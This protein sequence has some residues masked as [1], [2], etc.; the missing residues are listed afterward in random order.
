MAAASTIT[1]ITATGDTTTPCTP[2]I[3]TGECVSAL[4]LLKHLAC[5]W[6]CI[7][8]VLVLGPIATLAGNLGVL[9]DM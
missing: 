1:D 2:A 9:S 6:L 4:D 3:P 8:C 5:K 7:V